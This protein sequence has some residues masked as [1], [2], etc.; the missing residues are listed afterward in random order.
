MTDLGSIA[1][2]I[3]I[4]FIKFLAEFRRVNDAFLRHR[5]LRACG[6]ISANQREKYHPIKRTKNEV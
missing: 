4:L 3:A 1:Y 6:N 2:T 5:L